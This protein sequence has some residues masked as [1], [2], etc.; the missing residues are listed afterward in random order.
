MHASIA[1]ILLG[2]LGDVLLFSP[3]LLALRQALP[4]APLTLFL[5]ERSLPALAL[6]SEVDQA[7]PLQVQGQP[8]WRLAWQLCQ[9]LRQSHFDVVL[10][11]G[12]SPMIAAMLA[13]SGVRQRVGYDTG[14]WTRRLLTHRAPLDKQAYAGQ[15]YVS[16]A[17]A[18]LSDVLGQ[19]EFS[20]PAIPSL[21]PPSPEIMHWAQ[22][23]LGETNGVPGW[24]L[25]HPGVSQVGLSKGIDKTW[26]AASWARLAQQLIEAGH[27]V[28]LV[29]GPDDAQAVAAIL[30]ALPE[31]ARTHPRF[32]N[33]YGQTPT[34]LHLAGL[35]HAAR[36]LVAVDSSPMHLAV[37]LQTPVVAI[38][39]PTNPK[40]LLPYAS[41]CQAV[42]VADLL[43]RPCLW[44]VRQRNC[45]TPV[46]LEVPVSAVWEALGQVLQQP[47]L[48][49]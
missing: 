3:V 42:T 5:E 9:R 41:F 36:V 1:C 33:L 46:C 47:Q 30:D 38:F 39:G 21:Q 8:K 4:A 48:K 35:I 49:T 25:L 22:A 17:N 6:L 24:V 19:P 2:G 45:D 37:G 11:A 16:L 18:W 34:F 44:D 15:M 7:I 29:G 20:A 14:H 32:Q 28:A 27:P 26:P 12:S 13:L 31:A 43:C 40:K 23:Q 10:S